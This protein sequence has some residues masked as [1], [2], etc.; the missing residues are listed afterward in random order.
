MRIVEDEMIL[1]NGLK[2][3][4]QKYFPAAQIDH[5]PSVEEGKLYFSENE[6]PDLFFCDIELT[7]GTS[8]E[9]LDHINNNKPVIFC[10]AFNEYA[11]DAFKRLGVAYILKPYSKEE[12]ENAIGSYE[13][14]TNIKISVEDLQ[15]QVAGMPKSGKLLLYKG[16]NII[17]VTYESIAV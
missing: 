11:V 13:T 4:L 6:L 10:T 3:L 9:L 7:D 16:E 12:L 1:A 2:S 17:P 14:L 5:V 15:P 8:F